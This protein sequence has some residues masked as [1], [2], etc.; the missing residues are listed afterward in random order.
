MIDFVRALGALYETSGKHDRITAFH[1]KISGVNLNGVY[2]DMPSLV[3]VSSNQDST[4][5]S[6][7]ASRLLQ[8]N[9]ASL[10]RDNSCPEE[11][12]GRLSSSPFTS[13]MS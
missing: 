7:K 8:K 4:I 13:G 11:E 6:R 12:K 5:F 10:W 1:L 2:D 3:A 9:A